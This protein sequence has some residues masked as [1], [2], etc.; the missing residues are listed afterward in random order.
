MN[1]YKSIYSE[2]ITIVTKINVFIRYRDIQN[3]ISALNFQQN[4]NI[5]ICF[6]T[7]KKM[8]VCN[9]SKPE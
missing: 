5:S 4:S 2:I 8:S 6:K 9:K 7:I 1:N 3:K